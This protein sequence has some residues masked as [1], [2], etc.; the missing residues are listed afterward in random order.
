M[1][2]FECFSQTKQQTSPPQENKKGWTFSHHLVGTSLKSKQH[3]LCKKCPYSEIFL[4]RM[5]ENAN[6]KNAENEY[7]LCSDCQH[8]L[9]KIM[10]M[11]MKTETSN[12]QIM[13]NKRFEIK[14]E[15]LMLEQ[16]LFIRYPRFFYESM[17]QKQ[18]YSWK[19]KE[20]GRSC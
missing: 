20:Y 12:K 14:G 6:Q 1:A 19:T 13:A 2:V 11:I 17:S 15:A 3:S 7:F 5:R 18:S 16:M 8:L 4:V 9:L 10:K